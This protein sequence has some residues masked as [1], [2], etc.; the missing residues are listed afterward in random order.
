MLQGYQIFEN[1]PAKLGCNAIH[2]TRIVMYYIGSIKEL[3]DGDVQS[4][5]LN[6]SDPFR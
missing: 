4:L 6:A 1:S 2:N 3:V 5:S